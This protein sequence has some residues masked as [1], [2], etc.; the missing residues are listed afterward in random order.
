M[1][2]TVGTETVSRRAAV[3]AHVR[4]LLA[5]GALRRGSRLPSILE[6]ARTLGVAKNTVIDALDRLCT[7]G[8]LESRERQG[9]FVRSAPRVARSKPTRIADLRVDAVA[10]GMATILVQTGGGGEDLVTV[11][12]GTTCESVLSTRE[13]TQTLKRA[14]PRDPTKG[15]RYADPLGEPRL[16]DVIASYVGS[17]VSPDRVVVTHGAI[18]ALNLAFATVVA[19]TGSRRIAIESPGYFMIP[20]MLTELGIEPVAI[21]R[22]EEGFDVEALR[23]EAKRAPLAAVMINTNHHNPTGHTLSLAQ[24]F[25]VAALAQERG[26]F[27]LEDDVYKG[28]WFRDEEPPTI[29]SLLPERTVYL[30]SFSKTLGAGLRV[31]FMLAPSVL[32]EPLQRKKFLSTL[33]GDAHTQNVV[34]DFVE[35][36]GYARHLQEM[37]E[38]L[39]RR[40]R[41]A[42]VQ[43]ARFKSLGRFSR[44]YAGGLFWRFEF[45]PGVDPMRLY[46]AARQKNVLISPGSFFRVNPIE[47]DAGDA[48]MRVNVSRCQG[49]ALEHVLSVLGEVASA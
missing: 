37:R 36:R 22:T 17:H 28:L 18:E 42:E 13:W 39:S 2:S 23:A 4:S 47:A 26:I 11:G 45:R 15:L 38:E 33:S 43:S 35:G 24:R 10:H 41:I 19:A 46:V 12:S 21:P 49:T 44:P 29:H 25:E 9:F 8:I 32:L 31:G 30:S 40:S 7:E 1:Q 6:L 34:A 27:V 48:W 14:E 5:S 20:S 3:E 16:R